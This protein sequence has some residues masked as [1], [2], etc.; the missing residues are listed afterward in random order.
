MVLFERKLTQFLGR[1]P[2]VMELAAALGQPAKTVLLLQRMR[3]PAVSLEALNDRAAQVSAS[4]GNVPEL[5]GEVDSA[6][7]EDVSQP[8]SA[9]GAGA[10]A[11]V[12]EAAITLTINDLL[13]LLA[14]RDACILAMRYGLLDGQERPATQVAAKLGIST[15][16]V[17]QRVA[18]CLRRLHLRAHQA[19]LV[20]HTPSHYP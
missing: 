9:L 6:D 2:T 13:A 11:A 8:C 20:T 4:S 10:S 17:L 14:P 12:R 3:R 5:V 7:W 18:I 16:T 15:Q 19:D 1:R